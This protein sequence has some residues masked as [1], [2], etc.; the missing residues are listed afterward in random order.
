ML[1]GSASDAASDATSD[2]ATDAALDKE[3]MMAGSSIAAL[4]E[5]AAPRARQSE[6]LRFET[7]ADVAPLYESWCDL[8]QRSA[9]ATIFQSADWCRAWVE[10]S[11][12]AGVAESPR[13]ATVWRGDRLVLLWPLAIRRL[14]VFRILHALAEPATQYGDVLI[15]AREDRAALLDMAWKEVR[16]WA[17][18]DAIEL[19]RVRDGSALS[20]LPELVRHDVKGS[21]ASAPL[22]DFRQ[23]DA[24]SADGQRTSK[25]RNALR[26][27]ERLLAE[28][29]PVAFDIL[30]RRQD[31]CDVLA[32]AFRLKREWQKEKS[33]VSAGYAHPASEASLLRLAG[34]GQLFAARLRVG[35]NTAA[36]ELGAVRNRQ[37]WSL[38]QSYDLRFSKH[39]PGRLLFWHLLE[40]CPSLSIDVFD[41]LAPAHR[42][43]LEWSNRETGIRDYLMPISVRGRAAVSYL[44]N[45]KPRLR[46]LYIR[47]PAGLRRRAARLVHELS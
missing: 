24:D 33:A 37:Y 31:Q 18:I 29:G 12:A 36:I 45:V 28:L 11:E 25:T 14:S 30:D 38:V 7:Y 41:F 39:A 4:L 22:L 32:E 10:A 6:V 47:L 16:S 3:E 2:S 8:E 40:T 17:G 20:R 44:L 1:P 42:H 34:D 35:E 21:Q 15:D 13:I 26:R 5:P 23:L 9:D 43:K 27:H 46:E 19:R